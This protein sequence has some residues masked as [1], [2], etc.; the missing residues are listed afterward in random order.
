MGLPAIVTAISS[1][2]QGIAQ[3][4]AEQGIALNL[5]WHANL[6]EEAIREALIS[7]LH[8]HERRVQMSERG[9]KLIDGQGAARV[10]KF[11]QNSL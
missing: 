11:L 7:L 6:S 3:G 4:L 5:D 10:V 2:Q 8:D 9:R 1:D